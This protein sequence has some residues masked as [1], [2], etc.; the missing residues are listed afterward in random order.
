[1]IIRYGDISETAS[2]CG[3]GSEGTSTFRNRLGFSSKITQ[4]QIELHGGSLTD[5]TCL[6]LAQHLMLWF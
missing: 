1:M 4:N 5:L 2:E 3:L 6:I